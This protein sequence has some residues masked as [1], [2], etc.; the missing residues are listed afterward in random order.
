MAR[1]E[2]RGSY[3][4]PAVPIQPALHFANFLFPTGDNFLGKPELRPFSFFELSLGD[5]DGT[6]LLSYHS[7]REVEIGA[8]RTFGI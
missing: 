2:N 7:L 1:R 8:A 5:I 3:K 6:T 4:L